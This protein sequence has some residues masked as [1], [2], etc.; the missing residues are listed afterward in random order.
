MRALQANYPALT[1]QKELI[2]DEYD[3]SK[4]YDALQNIVI[5]LRRMQGNIAS[6]V[7]FNEVKEFTGDA[8]TTVESGQMYIWNDSD[9]ASGQPTHYLVYNLGGTTVRFASVEV[10]S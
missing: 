7:T 5:Q 8:I 4:L 1:I 10:A 3:A 9:A 2:P 6:I